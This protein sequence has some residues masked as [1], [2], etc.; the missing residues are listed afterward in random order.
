MPLDNTHV[1]IPDLFESH[2]RYFSEKEAVVCGEVRRNW[3]DF[4]QNINRVANALLRDGIGKGSRVAV[5]MD[6]SIDMLEMVFGA[7][8]SGACV[9]PLS[10]LLTGP[11]LAGLIDDSQAVAVFASAGFLGR[12]NPYTAQLTRVVSARRIAMS[13]SEP[14]WVDFSAYADGVDYTAPAVRYALD[15]EF[16][17]I[18]SSGTTGLP[19]GI[20]QTHGARLHWAFSNAIEMGFTRRSKAL[21]TT[22]LYSNGTWLVMLPA[23]FV[24]GTVVAMPSFNA[25]RMLELVENEKIT[26]TFMVPTQYV[27][28]L[29][30]PSLAK[31][32]VSSLE[33]LLS[34]G[35]PLRLDTKRAV[36][37]HFGDRLIEL[38]GY[39]EGYASML[40]PGQ[41]EAH[42]DSV[43]VPVLGWEIRIL[44]DD[45]QPVPAG[46]AGEIAGYGAGMMA[47]YHQQPAETEKL[48]WRDERGRTFIRSGDIGVMDEA[49]FLRIVDRKKDMIIS[50][51]FNVFPSD[52]ESVVAQHPGVLDVAVI[53]IPHPKWGEV[54]LALVVLRAEQ[55]CE[56]S[57]ISQWC[58]E[59]LAKHQRLARVEFRTEFP[60]N[61]LGKVLKRELRSKYWGEAATPETA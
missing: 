1:F 38:Y 47:A 5:L 51:G 46:V 30:E 61:A 33:V 19:K 56:A 13:S 29:G 44:G 34:A 20:L 25:A 10:G 26:H 53:S 32:D 39:S 6:N 36:I 37:A 55:A 11:Q 58:N 3:R 28:V 49:G 2:G 22:A 17:I 45:G 52:I 40:K 7:V 14:G 54:P 23:L 50:G 60:R 41:H 35:S 9:V 21:T 27:M 42:P 57:D 48:I 24:G 12:L 31:H 16:N 18:Y 4:S 43:G 8:K 15:D 59:R